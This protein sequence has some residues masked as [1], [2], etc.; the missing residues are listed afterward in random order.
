M[1]R[2]DAL[3]GTPWYECYSSTIGRSDAHESDVDSIH[4]YDVNRQNRMVFRPEGIADELHAWRNHYDIAW[5]K[6]RCRNVMPSYSVGVFSSGGCLDTL[7]AIRASFTPLWGSECC[8]IKS[9]MWED[10]TATPSYPDTFKHDWSSVNKVTLLKSGQTCIDYSLSG[11]Y[12]RGEPG[13]RDGATGWMFTAQMDSIL[14]IRPKAF[15]LEMVSSATRVHDGS[16][17]DEVVSRLSEFYHV[18][19]EDNFRVWTQGD[20]SNRSRMFI[21]GFDREH[22]GQEGARF[23]FPKPTFDDRRFPIALDVC[24]PDDDVP[25]AYIINDTPFMLK[26]KDP[27][28]GLL[29]KLAKS[30]ESM[31][32]SSH[33]NSVYSWLS[34]FN[35]TTTYGGGGRFPMLSYQYDGSQIDKTRKIT[36]IEAVRVASLPES[37]ATWARMFGEEESFQSD[38]HLLE[39]VASVRV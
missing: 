11:P 32:L 5:Y 4:I 39:C 29:H 33:P 3:C 31:G 14:T 35:T 38:S 21:V 12:F 17:V 7:A 24:I 23:Q 9:K 25:E 10:L 30:G 18:H 20:V 28:P 22:V 27:K 26:W 34:L 2:D 15:V 8:P 1:S 19:K 13:G 16:E 36:P 37:Y 6:D